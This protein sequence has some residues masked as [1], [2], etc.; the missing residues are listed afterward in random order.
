M[1]IDEPHRAESRDLVCGPVLQALPALLGSLRSDL[2]T[3]FRPYSTAKPQALRPRRRR[4]VAEAQTNP[5]FADL[6][7]SHFVQAR[8]DAT[9]ELVVRARDRGEIAANTDLEVTL[10]LFMAPS[11]TA[12]C[13]ATPPLRA[14]RQQVID[15]VIAAISE[16][17]HRIAIKLCRPPARDC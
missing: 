6:Y 4:P 3:R 5:D 7:R 9:C 17:T 13:M 14:I 15:Y 11:T 1:D 2:L 16:R 10:D 12:C 8:R